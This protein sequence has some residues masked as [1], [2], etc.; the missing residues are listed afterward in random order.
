MA[1]LAAP[2][3]KDIGHNKPSQVKARLQQTADDLGQVGTDPFYGKGRI[4]V[5]RAWKG[6]SK[7]LHSGGGLRAAA[8]PLRST[9]VITSL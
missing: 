2:I 1:G 6:C 4:N 3:V 7:D 8:Q 9:F 5:P